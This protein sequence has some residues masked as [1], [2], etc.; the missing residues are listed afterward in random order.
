MTIRGL[1]TFFENY[2]GE[3]YSGVFLDA[4]AGY[5][6]NSSPDFRK[7]AAT[8]IIKRF[9]RSFGKSP[10]PSEIEQHMKEILQAIPR[11]PSLPERKPE[12][13]E[14]EKKESR[15]MFKNFW[16]WLKNKREERGSRYV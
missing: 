12:M 14:V 11:A 6:K 3:K 10:G 13:T 1:L 4:M 5:L 8:V 7:A 15:E 2:Y 16:D 9:S